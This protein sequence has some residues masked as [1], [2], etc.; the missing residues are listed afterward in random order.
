[1]TPRKA[2]ERKE[3]LERA[4]AAFLAGAVSPETP[5]RL[6]DY[7]LQR[8]LAKA[9]ASET[10]KA[11]ASARRVYR[12]PAMLRHVLAVILVM[13][14]VM[15][16]STSGAYAFSLNAQPGSTLYGAKI[17]FERTRVTLHPSRSGD[18]RLE[19]TFSERRMEELREM[20][21]SGNRL[22]AERWLREYRRNI[23]GA[24][25]LFESVPAQE[26]V[27]LS[28]QFQEMLARQA[29]MML[30]LRAGQ[31]DGLSGTITDAYHVCDQER[32]RMRRRCGQQ[33]DEG[34]GQ[35][36][37]GPEGQGRGDCTYMEGLTVAEDMS[38]SEDIEPVDDAQVSPEGTGSSPSGATTETPAV[39]SADPY[40]LTGTGNGQSAQMAGDKGYRD[41]MPRGGHVP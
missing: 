15:I 30:G 1:M 29:Q 21:A 37:G 36:P 38:L 10:G 5:D 4:A 8:V 35:E 2:R 33:G 26:V 27:E 3:E 34:S 6:R 11:P 41:D 16:I 32:E 39:S 22:G 18:I 20:A 31:P 7:G 13:L 17:L 19:M 40:Q 23:E 12:N 24:G 25:V 9:R 28:S 14:L